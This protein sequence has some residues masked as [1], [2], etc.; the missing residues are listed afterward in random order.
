M[1]TFRRAWKF[2]LDTLFPIECVGCKKEGQWLC[3]NCSLRLVVEEGN[4]CFV[5]KIRAQGGRTCFSC[6]N[7]CGFSAAIRFFDYSVPIV[8]ELLHTAKYKFVKEA[9]TPL[10]YAC[11]PFLMSKLELFDID[12]RATLFVP[13]PLHPRRLRNRG[14]NQSEIIA[15][16]FATSAGAKCVTALHRLHMRPPQAFLNEQDRAI[17]MK[18]NI[19]CINPSVVYG[20]SVFLIDDVATT[21]A[22]LDECAQVLRNAGASKV[23]AIVLAK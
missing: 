23:W 21:G 5:C 11:E 4:F 16:R 20:Q 15:T 7:I 3:A 10:L 2:F 1:V 8:K 13:V 17:N 14:F 9:L 19:G 18:G 6:Q 12:L 22:T